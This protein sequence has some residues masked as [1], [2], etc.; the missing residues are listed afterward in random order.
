MSFTKAF[1]VIDFPLF[2]DERGQTV[3]IEFDESFPFDPQRTYFVTGNQGWERGAHAHLIEQEVFVVV[4][5]SVTAVLHDGENEIEICLDKKHK[6]LYV[7]QMVWHTFKNFS[8]D[9]LMV[10]FSSTHYLP[11]EQNYI[12]DF[13]DFLKRKHGTL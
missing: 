9:A 3:P 11:G 4:S 8:E 12:L 1:Q 6:G 7:A 13:Q 10:C 2:D 5:G